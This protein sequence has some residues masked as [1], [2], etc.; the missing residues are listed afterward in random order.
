M[1]KN[2]LL[3][4]SA[5]AEAPAPS[6]K[7]TKKAKARSKASA[8]ASA[9]DSS[10]GTSWPAWLTLPGMDKAREAW[11]DERIRTVTGLITLGTALIF[12][13]AIFSSFFTGVLDIRLVQ[14]ALGPGESEA[15]HNVLGAVGAHLGFVLAR[16]G[17]G[18]GSLLVPFF[19]AVF[20]LRW[21]TDKPIVPLGKSL[22][23]GLFLALYVPLTLA[24]VSRQPTARTALRGLRG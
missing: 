19:L 15:F 24:F 3:S 8:T 22:R 1:A 9:T 17:L 13:L 21:L 14:Q 10:D 23:L 2:V 20:G 18:I 7:R 16:Q 6:R 4:D 12:A 11:A 5:A